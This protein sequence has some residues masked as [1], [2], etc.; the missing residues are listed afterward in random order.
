MNNTE[1]RGIEID[2][3]VNGYVRLNGIY[4]PNDV[5]I[6]IQ[7]F[8]GIIYNVYHNKPN[9]NEIDYVIHLLKPVKQLGISA[10]RYNAN[11]IGR[12]SGLFAQNNIPVLS[13]IIQI[14]NTKITDANADIVNVGDLIINARKQVPSFFVFRVKKEFTRKGYHIQFNVTNKNDNNKFPYYKFNKYALNDIS[15]IYNGLEIMDIFANKKCINNK[16]GINIALFIHCEM[17]KDIS[18]TIADI[19]DKLHTIDDDLECLYVNKE[20]G[21]RIHKC[22]RHPLYSLKDGKGPLRGLMFIGNHWYNDTKYW[23]SMLVDQHKIQEFS[24]FKKPP[25]ISLN[26][27]SKYGHI[28]LSKQGLHNDDPGFRRAFTHDERQLIPKLRTYFDFTIGKL[29]KEYG[30]RR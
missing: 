1:N 24:K 21:N 8:Y 22:L 17:D 13:K 3:C 20:F 14:N 25:S 12:V 27:F 16:C 11:F 6:L 26:E 7:Y 19:K 15:S 23:C 29:W 4:I 2:S 10:F 9:N 28:I 5:I 30:I 18:G